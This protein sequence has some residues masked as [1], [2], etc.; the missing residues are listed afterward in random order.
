MRS[1]QLYYNMYGTNDR[2]GRFSGLSTNDDD[3]DRIPSDHE[4]LRT[5]FVRQRK[6]SGRLVTDEG[7]FTPIILKDA[8]INDFTCA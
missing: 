7:K 8:G 2:I 3:D 4:S 5:P 6:E 1:L